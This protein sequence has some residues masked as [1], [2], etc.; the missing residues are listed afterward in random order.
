MEVGTITFEM[1]VSNLCEEVS[2]SSNQMGTIWYFD[3]NLGEDVMIV[4]DNQFQNMFEIYKIEMHCK[5]L[6]VVVEKTSFQGFQH[7]SISEQHSLAEDPLQNAL[8][9]LTE[10]LV[11]IPPDSPA[12]AAPPQIAAAEPE[13]EQQPDIFDNA[14]EYVGTNDEHFYIPIPLAQPTFNAQPTNDDPNECASGEGAIPPEA[15]VIDAD[16]EEIRVLHDPENTKI[17]KGAFFPD[18]DAFRK[19]ITHYAVKTGFEFAKGRKS[20]RTRFIARCAH[21]SCPWRIHASRLHDK[22]TIQV[23]N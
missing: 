15:E 16:P 18:I 22:K 23:Y 9:K 11:V 13:A 7:H 14:E 10:P 5:V 6:L 2:W 19:A 8:E 20:D 4:D 3:K 1:L 17:E 12:N 21:P